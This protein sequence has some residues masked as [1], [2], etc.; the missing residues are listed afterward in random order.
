MVFKSAGQDGFK[1]VSNLFVFLMKSTAGNLRNVHGSGVMRTESCLHCGFS[2]VPECASFWRA[3]SAQALP[4]SLLP[5]AGKQHKSVT[6][7]HLL[8]QQQQQ[9][10]Y[11]WLQLQ[12]LELVNW[13]LFQMTNSKFENLLLLMIFCQWQPTR[14]KAATGYNQP[15]YLLMNLTDMTHDMIQTNKRSWKFDT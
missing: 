10:K 5:P 2:S 4:G 3:P 15:Q 8:Q 12:L 7:L 6:Y 14:G 13:Y 11:S 1:L 9:D